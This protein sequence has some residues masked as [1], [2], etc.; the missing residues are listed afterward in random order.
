MI[1]PIQMQSLKISGNS[2]M[3]I[4]IGGKRYTQINSLT[5]F[6]QEQKEID[7]NTFF[8]N[9]FTISNSVLLFCVSVENE[10]YRD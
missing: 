8:L 4:N 1:G 3:H 6:L 5:V 9:L 10:L 2:L 7:Q